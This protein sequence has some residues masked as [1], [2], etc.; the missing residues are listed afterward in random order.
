MHEIVEY[1]LHYCHV[2]VGEILDRNLPMSVINEKVLY[3]IFVV[4]ITQHSRRE[5]YHLWKPI[6]N[7]R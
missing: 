7:S 1:Y 5:N 2:Q 6:F 4:W 3:K